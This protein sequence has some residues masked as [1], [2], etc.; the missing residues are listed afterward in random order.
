MSEYHKQPVKSNISLWITFYSSNRI[1]HI[2]YY[3]TSYDINKNG[4]ELNLIDAY[5]WNENIDA[6]QTTK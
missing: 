2:T 3:H 4:K 6:V 1:N 5:Q